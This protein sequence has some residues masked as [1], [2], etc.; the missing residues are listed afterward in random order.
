MI[1]ERD[2]RPPPMGDN[3]PP[4]EQAPIPVITG[5]EPPTY[6]KVKTKIDDLIGEA[7][8]WID[9]MPIQNQGQA[10]GVAKLKDLLRAAAS[11]ADKARVIENKPFD[12]GK[13]EVQTRYN[14]LIADTKT[15]KGSATIALD[16][17]GATLTKWLVKLDDERR[18]DAEAK[19]KEADVLAKA[20]ADAAQEAYGEGASLEQLEGLEESIFAAKVADRDANRAE[21]ARPAAIGTGRATTL[22][23][24]YVPVMANENKALAYFWKTRRAELVEFALDLA[25]KEI[26]AGKRAIPGFEIKEEK[27][28]I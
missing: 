23:T 2:S 17:I 26:A 24:Y 9:G 15:Q 14:A 12:D 25:R 27:R 8:N 18:A 28:A 10:D 7:R 5:A 20:V 1:S 16:A 13:A 6:A 3:N 4:P 19:R 11:E 21:T 22:R